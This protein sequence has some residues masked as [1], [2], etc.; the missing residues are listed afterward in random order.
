ML[1]VRQ[2]V[3]DR[4]NLLPV[5][6]SRGDEHPAVAR[7]QPLADRVRAECREER[8]NDAPCL[9]SADH[10]DVQLW[11]PAAQREHEIT[12]LYAKPLKGIREPVA[13]QRERCEGELAGR[14][15]LGDESQCDDVAAT[16][17][18]VPIDRRVRDVHAAQR[19]A[20]VRPGEGRSPALVVGQ[21][22]R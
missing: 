5:C 6:R 8:G 11:Q 4:R 20:R 14:G 21:V 16:L 13:L 12:R 18:H 7:P 2:V 22:R 15:K 3:A 17:I 9:E 19:P 10:R 1:E